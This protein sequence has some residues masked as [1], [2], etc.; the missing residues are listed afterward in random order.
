MGDFAELLHPDS[1]NTNDATRL[2]GAIPSDVVWEKVR[3]ELG[4]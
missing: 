2:P 3:A 1:I 4:L